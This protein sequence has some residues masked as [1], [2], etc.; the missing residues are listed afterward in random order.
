MN[1]RALYLDAAARWQ[2]RLDDGVALNI[3]GPGRA[4]GL[5][6]LTRLARV[7]SPWHAE[8]T[9]QALLACLQAGV[10][11]L[12]HDAHGEPVGW[13]FGPRR[14]ETTLAALLREGLAQSNWN[15]EFAA[16][17]RAV[18]RRLAMAALSAMQ[19]GCCRLD[20]AAVRVQLCNA[21]RRR[22]GHS[23][24]AHL[25][26]LHRAAAAL[27]GEHLQREVGDASLIGY[28]RPGL[29]LGAVFTELLEWPLHLLLWQ[30]PAADIVACAPA[31]FAAAAL[32]RHAALL[33]RELGGL[34][35]G[36]E[37]HLREWLW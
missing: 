8:W 29:H 18:E 32:E 36:L 24:G 33:H 30:T 1:A 19:A 26:A 15:D 22:I 7:V 21:H 13:C 3:S 28:R 12:F 9:M 20:P 35:G 23:I 34:L 14:R 5:Y 16:W 2:V 10:P 27:V 25:R 6:P 4:R 17:R 11:V 31:R 37:L